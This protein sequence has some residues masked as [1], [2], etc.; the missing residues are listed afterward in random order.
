MRFGSRRRAEPVF[1]LTPLIDILFIVLIFLVLTTSFRDVSTLPVTLPAA[2]SSD[3]D[4]QTLPGL[5][6]VSIADDGAL[7]FQG[8]RV[9]FSQLTTL[10]AAIERPE[11][12]IVRLRADA[13]VPHGRVV[14]VLDALRSQE[15][16]QLSIETRIASDDR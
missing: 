5:I 9:T 7:A 16:N 6:T 12:A 2:A 1:N 15:I 3:P 4:A 8:N 11:L 13:A 14:Q 10:L